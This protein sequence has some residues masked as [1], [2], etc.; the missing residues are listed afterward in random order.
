MKQILSFLII[1]TAITGTSKLSAENNNIQRYLNKLKKDTLFTDAVVGVMVMD[2]KGRTIASWNPDMPL[3][4]ASTMKTVTTGIALNTLGSGYKFSTKLAYSGSVK[5]GV[6]YGDLY[7]I[8]GGDPTLGSRDTL[9]IPLESLFGK[10]IT[11]VKAAGINR[12]EGNII[13]DNTFFDQEIVPVSW[14]WSNLGPSYGS[15]TSGLSFYENLQTITLLPGINAGD[16]PLIEKSFPY[17]PNMN[18]IN[19]LT[20]GSA[21]SGIRTSYFTSD[22]AKTAL[23]R[24]SVP[25][26]LDSANITVSNK[27]PHLGCAYE[28]RSYLYK[29]GI[30]SF[31]DIFEVSQKSGL[32]LE[33][34]TVIEETLSPPLTSIIN[35]TNKISNNFYAETLLKTVGKHMTG[36]GSYDSAFVAVRRE[37]ERIGAGSKGFTQADGSG[38]SRQNYVSARFFCN[39]FRAM[40]DTKEFDIFFNSLP[41]PGGGGTLKSVLQS[42]GQ[43]KYK[44]HAKSGSLANVRCYAGYV[45]RGGDLLYFAI[46]TNNFSA[47]TA[48]MQIGIE[49]FMHELIKF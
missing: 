2:A 40:K 27:F 17:V 46:L 38:L 21:N 13:A 45:E 33:N 25:S 19:R 41:Q 30:Y 10:W 44:I 11:S 18:Y 9:A 1:L 43:E 3:L 12:I 5:G 36:V 29:N 34:L 15:G 28:F 26:G 48:Q 49:G 23:L 39:F 4:T 37:L 16:T 20:T 47:R 31:P 6:L 14:A 24:G 7:I 35:V 22:L 8:G 42:V 32:N